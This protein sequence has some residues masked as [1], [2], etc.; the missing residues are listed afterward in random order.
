MKTEEMKSTRL[1]T[2]LTQVYINPPGKTNFAPYGLA[3]RASGYGLRS[4]ITR[5]RA[6]ELADGEAGAMGFLAPNLDIDASALKS[7]LNDSGMVKSAAEAAF[8][9]AAKAAIAGAYDIVVLDGVLDLVMQDSISVSVSEI[10]MLM[11]EK[12][13]H[14]E[15][16]LTGSDTADE[17]LEKAHLI[18]EMKV[19]RETPGGH[20]S[21]VEVV[22]G[23]GKGKTTYCLG[24]ALLMSG[25]GVPSFM[26]QLIKSPRLYGEVMASQNLPGMQI[27]SMGKGL[28]G[29]RDPEVNTDH[30]KAAREA[31]RNAKEVVMSRRYGLVVLDE[32]NIAVN[33]GFIGPE[34]VLGLIAGIPNELRL[35]LSGRYAHS[36]I[37]D[38]ATLAVEMK[39]IKHPYEIGVKAR[40]GIEY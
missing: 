25:M 27:Q 22:T 36:E 6:H 13:M 28:V 29:K 15:L 17:I 3:L 11:R 23:S 35:M 30:K 14:V 32:I 12:A 7:G 18:T 39:M 24:K 16:L 4:L 20:G 5:F 2:G 26:L 21:R 1:K 10:L 9:N 38:A 19:H 8:Q 33:Y 34:E 37:V 31:W 40:K